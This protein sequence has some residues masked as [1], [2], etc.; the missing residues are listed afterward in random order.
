MANMLL[1]E[2]CGP[3][4]QSA[5]SESSLAAAVDKVRAIGFVG[6]TE[7]WLLSVCL[8]HAKFGGDMLKAELVN[9][10]KAPQPSSEDKLVYILNSTG[11]VAADHAMYTAARKRFY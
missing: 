8:F 3:R 10:R 4:K 5:L 11:F 2:S 7:E 9:V 1:G 6:L